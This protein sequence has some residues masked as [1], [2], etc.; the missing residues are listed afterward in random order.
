MEFV[1]A[2]ILFV[3]VVAAVVLYA[4]RTPDVEISESTLEAERH[5]RRRDSEAVTL[6]RGTVTKVPGWDPPS[7]STRAVIDTP[8]VPVKKDKPKPVK[9]S[10]PRRSRGSSSGIDTTAIYGGFY[11]GSSYGGSDCGSSY[12]SGSSGGDSGGGGGCD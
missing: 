7:V 11:S 4:L 6:D 5:V 12:D 10:A 3:A 8:K 2:G 9:R 1:V